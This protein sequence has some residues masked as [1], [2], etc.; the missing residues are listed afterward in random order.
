MHI[1]MV[2]PQP[3]FRPRGTPFS[4][5]HRLRG[6]SRLGHTVDLVTYPFG[7]SPS[8]PGVR[9]LRS[10]RPPLTRDVG[11]GPSLAKLV[12]DL[13]LFRTATALARTGSHDLVHTHEEAGWL[14]AWLKR[15]FGLPHLYDMHSSL[16]Q[17][18][19]NFS[20]F[21]WPPLRRA[22]QRLEQHTLDGADAVIAICPELRDYVLASGYKGRVWL[23]ENTLD[24]EPPALEP[25]DV[26]TLRQVHGLG[27][28][29]VVL[30]TGTL[31]TYQGLDLLIAAAPCVLREHGD[32]RF[33]LVG[34]TTQQVAALQQEASSFGV[35][36]AFRFVPAVP[37]EDVFLY[38]RMS[39]V[40]VTTRSRG[41]NTPLKIYQYLRAGKPIVAT[42]IRSH[43]QVLDHETAELVAPTV[44]GV[45]G[46]IRR[47]LSDSERAGQLASS[48]AR[49]AADRYS[50][51]A[52]MTELERALAGFSAMRAAMQPRVL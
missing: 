44:E 47:V 38:H 48:A 11:I 31:E 27:E 13:P 17:Q 18:L 33:V 6:L 45:S 14:G 34:G 24:L 40:L 46:G 41:T 20:R 1:L 36:H 21:D 8:I 52:Y 35:S 25:G 5:L 39:D 2:A 16:P 22:F 30:Y 10:G 29:P 50:E 32:A 3:F 49:L 51:S 28:G 26:R 12:L 23:I 37:P 4:V 15:R 19:G 43:T 7:E 42:D 9:I